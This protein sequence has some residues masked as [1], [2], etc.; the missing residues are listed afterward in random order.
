MQYDRTTI[1]SSDRGNHDNFSIAGFAQSRLSVG[2][3]FKLMLGVRA[4]Q[5]DYYG[6]HFVPQITGTYIL[7][8]LVLRSSIGQ[9]VRNPDY[10]ERFV[11]YNIEQLSPNRNAGNPDVQPEKS[12]SADLNANWSPSKKLRISPVGFLPYVRQSNRLHRDQF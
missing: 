1:E 5:D 12:F 9:S 2:E 6:F 7:P 11:S 4:E 3:K 10:T 8:K